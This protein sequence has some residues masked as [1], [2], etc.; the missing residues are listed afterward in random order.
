MMM[1][2]KKPDAVLQKRNAVKC[3]ATPSVWLFMSFPVHSQ[4]QE[5]FLEMEARHMETFG[6][7][8]KAAVLLM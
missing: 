2:I 8:A 3:A 6:T 1:S 5:V 4:K 7:G